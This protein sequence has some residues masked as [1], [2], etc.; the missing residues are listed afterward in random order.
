MT[1]CLLDICT[2]QPL[3]SSHTGHIDIT[4]G[5]DRPSRHTRRRVASYRTKDKGSGQSGTANRRVGDGV[6]GTALRSS[7]CLPRF[8]CRPQPLERHPAGRILGML[9][10]CAQNRLQWWMHMWVVST[11]N[12]LEMRRRNMCPPSHATMQQ[13]MHESWK[14]EEEGCSA[15]SACAS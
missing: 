12:S 10:S 3:E 4:S 8:S 11:P 2:S 7:W 14:S 15:V 1:P 9:S 5:A 6:Q 13:H